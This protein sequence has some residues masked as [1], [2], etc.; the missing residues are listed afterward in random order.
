[1][2]FAVAHAQLANMMRDMRIRICARD[3]ELSMNVDP[4]WM[5]RPFQQ[6]R[7]LS[8]IASWLL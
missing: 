3:T 5:S 4:K 6:V 1:M 2:L 8:R 7:T